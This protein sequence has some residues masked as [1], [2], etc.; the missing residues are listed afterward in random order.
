MKKSKLSVLFFTFFALIASHFTQGQSLESNP[1]KVSLPKK[2]NNASEQYIT[3]DLQQTEENGITLNSFLNE[4]FLKSLEAYPKYL[5][6]IPE[7]YRNIP[8]HDSV[9]FF[10]AEWRTLNL[11][12]QAYKSGDVT[13]KDLLELYKSQYKDTLGFTKQKYD[14]IAIYAV[15]FRKNKQFL[16]GDM[17]KNKD[18]GD[19][20]LFEYDSNFR[21]TVEENTQILNTVKSS[22]YSYEIKIEEKKHH[23]NRKFILY[24]NVNNHWWPNIEPKKRGYFSLFSLSDYWKGEKTINGKTMNIAYL[25]YMNKYGKLYVKPK[26]IPSNLGEYGFDKQFLYNLNDSIVINNSLY[27][28]DSVATDIAKVYLRKVKDVA[29]NYGTR[30]GSYLQDFEFQNLD[31]QTIA[32]QNIITEKPFTLLEFWGTWCG[33]CVALTPELKKTQQE[34]ASQLNMISIAVDQDAE[35][36]KKYVTKKKL[37]WTQGFIKQ[38]IPRKNKILENLAIDSYPTLFLIDHKGRILY[39]GYSDSLESIKNIIRK[40]T[41]P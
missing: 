20:H 25:G 40:L 18:F 36:V 39:R 37:N 19:D 26:E 29:K 34:F 10:T 32:T 3:I 2:E 24:P 35:R 27:V 41:K 31:N 9:Y 21:N 23:F 16:I 33:P 11:N 13:K 5:K 12:Y 14:N 38:E 1:R 17:N 22:N 6:S 15:G 8:A 28:T 4:H 30:I 7:T